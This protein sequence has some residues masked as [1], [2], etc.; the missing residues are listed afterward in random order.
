MVKQIKIIPINLR[1][2]MA[3]VTWRRSGENGDQRCCRRWAGGVEGCRG[4][5]GVPAMLYCLTWVPCDMLNCTYISLPYFMYWVIF[6]SEI[7][8][9]KVLKKTFSYKEK[10][11]YFVILPPSLR[12]ILSLH[13]RDTVRS[14]L[15]FSTLRVFLFT[16]VLL[17]SSPIWRF[18][19]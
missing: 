17:N 4:T 8:L 11:S 18:I 2:I 3:L 6:Q 12:K 10:L 9:K 19:Y 15:K 1:T 14:I 13:L 16:G 7:F 5:S